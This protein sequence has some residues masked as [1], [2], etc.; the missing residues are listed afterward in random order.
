M[1]GKL[2][3]VEG[4]ALA[5][6]IAANWEQIYNFQA[7]P[8]DILID[9]YPKSGTTWMQETVDLILH[10][11]DEKICMRAPVYERIPFIELLHMMKP[12]IE[13]VNA[14]PS[15]RVL[16]SHLPYQLVPPSFWKHNCKVIYV[17]RNARD[18][19]TSFY[20]FDHLVRFHPD[21]GLFEDYLQRF[22]KGDVGWGSWYDHVK[23][24]WAV[25][26]KPNILYVFF[27]DLKKNPSQEIRK[28]A[29]FLG[30]E[31]SEDLVTKIVNLSSFEH[32][33]NNPMA[34]YSE[35]PKELLDQSEKGFMRKG[36][37]G[38]WKTSFTAEQDKIFQLDYE[39]QMSD[40]TL[41]FPDLK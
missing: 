41:K 24:F 38:D 27:E 36:K 10:D 13:E 30:K 7:R 2:T 35:F 25:K 29:K 33:K 28:V 14:R 22:M 40:T 16:K 8:G 21:P 5:E 19:L 11:G 12:G 18:T 39:R 31:L 37:V 1:A 20:H 9:T 6:V 26:D 34:N 3:V 32:M 15:P 17:A 4:M 23:G